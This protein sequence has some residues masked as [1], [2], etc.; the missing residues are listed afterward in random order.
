MRRLNAMAGLCAVAGLLSACSPVVDD[1]ATRDG[2]PGSTRLAGLLGDEDRQAFAYALQPRPFVFPRDHG[3]H[4][5][6]RNDWWYVTGNLEGASG[7]R[8]GYEL[9]I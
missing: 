5:A 8:F 2:V 9:T 3:P 7:R 6:F 4:P 1:G